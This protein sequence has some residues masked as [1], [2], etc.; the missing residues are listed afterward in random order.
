MA[1]I[2]RKPARPSTTKPLRLACAA[3]LSFALP[4]AAQ[5]A[6]CRATP[7]P[8]STRIQQYSPPPVIKLDDSDPVG[9]VVWTHTFYQP[10]YAYAQCGSSGRSND[11]QYLSGVNNYSLGYWP[12]TVAGLGWRIQKGTYDFTH[13]ESMTIG[14]GTVSSTATTWVFSLVKTADTVGRGTLFF[15]NVQ[16]TFS[17]GGS[18]TSEYFRVW[19][20]E[21]RQIP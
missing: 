21:S 4:I 9:T 8:P 3:A 10:A 7:N 1:R 14:P 20:T 5:A 16:A 12:S 11:Q 6:D 18:R 19:T 15:P 2:T 13:P 17:L